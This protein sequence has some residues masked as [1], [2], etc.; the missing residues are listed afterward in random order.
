MLLNKKSSVADRADL[1]GFFVVLDG[2]T[3]CHDLCVCVSVCMR[4]VC[5][6]PFLSL[7]LFLTMMNKREKNEDRQTD[8]QTDIKKRTCLYSFPSLLYGHS[9]SNNTFSTHAQTDMKRLGGFKHE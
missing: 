4:A 6:F 8:R 1:S 9:G 5:V 2:G 7:S 3:A